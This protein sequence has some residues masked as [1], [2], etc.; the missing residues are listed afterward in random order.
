MSYWLTIEST[1]PIPGRGGQYTQTLSI[2]APDGLAG[3]LATL[4]QQLAVLMRNTGQPHQL[5]VS[6]KRCELPST[7]GTENMGL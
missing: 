7:T 1:R 3:G 6:W 5:V 2:W 4:A